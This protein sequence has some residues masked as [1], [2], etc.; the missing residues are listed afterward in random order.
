[1]YVWVTRNPGQTDPNRDI[2][3]KVSNGDKGSGRRRMTGGEMKEK[4]S[5]AGIRER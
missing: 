3:D 1:M 5:I 2:G 4:E